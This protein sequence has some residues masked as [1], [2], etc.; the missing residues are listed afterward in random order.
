MSDN[1]KSF[2]KKLKLILPILLAVFFGWLTFSRLPI[3]EI[4]PYF[5]TANYWWIA[6]GVV[7]G[8]FSHLSRAYRWNY[9]LKPMGY[10]IKIQNSVMSIFI[11]YLANFGIPRSG[12][13]LRAAVATNYE[14]IPFEKSFG[15][16]VTERI[17][18]LIM[19]LLICL[20]T[21]FFQFDFIYNILIEK[22]N[23]TKIIT[24]LL[25][26]SVVFVLMVLF[27]KKSKGKLANK[28]KG[29]VNGLL[30]G[31]TSVY[32]MENKGMFIFHTI[33]IWVMYVLMFYITSFSVQELHGAPFSSMIVAFIAA[34]F[35]IA[36]TNGGVFFY[37]AAVLS[38]LTLFGLAEEP[39][40]AFGWIVWTSQTLMI[41][42]FG[43]ISFIFLP[44]FNKKQLKETVKVNN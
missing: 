18:D 30:E 15:T 10:S 28:I 14:D 37:P 22:L 40:Y 20:I 13:V 7:F 27:I 11:A 24:L 5:K 21:L 4:I 39:S 44:I 12:E 1:K 43:I 9:M 26:L 31:I 6:L 41:I 8:M 23:P 2:L 38:A 36:A 33:F 35:T 29:F 42:V 25:G 32:K 17:F 34:S 19:I 3:S 16:I